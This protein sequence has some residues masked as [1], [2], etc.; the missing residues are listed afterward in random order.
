MEQSWSEDAHGT[1]RADG[2]HES[3]WHDAAENEQCG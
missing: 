3:K 1:S 2:P